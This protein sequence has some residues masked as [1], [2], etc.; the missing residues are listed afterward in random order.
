MKIINRFIPILSSFLIFFLIEIVFALPK[1]FYWAIILCLVI[2]FLGIY[3]LMDYNFKSGK[4]WRN[5]L[6]PVLFLSSCFIFLIFAEGNFLKHIFLGCFVALI[7]VFLE[8]IFVQYHFRP[9]YQVHSLENISVNINLLT[10]FLMTSG[11]FSLIIFLGLSLWPF[12]AA[13]A[14]ISLFLTHQIVWAS[15]HT[16]KTGW[17]H[18]VITALL[19]TEVFWVVSFLPVSVYVS[20]LVVTISYYLIT[21]LSRNWLLGIKEKKVVIR[22]L[23]IGVVSLIIIL[24]TAKWF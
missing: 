4:F 6:T 18:I 2:V 12:L 21:G 24:A 23:A 19:A 8:T 5:V 10:V 9:K 15:D 20:G 1:Q 16:I 22:Y 14:L 3:Q 11:F 17:R 7:W 13:F